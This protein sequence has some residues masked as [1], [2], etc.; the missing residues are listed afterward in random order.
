MIVSGAGA[1]K[2]DKLDMNCV[3]RK[4]FHYVVAPGG[5][6]G[7]PQEAGCRPGFR[8]LA[9][10]GKEMI[11]GIRVRDSDTTYIS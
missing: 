5:E 11:Y 9:D 1:R 3:E 10:G 7:E 2:L 8:D 4:K 6:L